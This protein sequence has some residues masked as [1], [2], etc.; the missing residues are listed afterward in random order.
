M[1]SSYRA[2]LA[3]VC[4]LYKLQ[5]DAMTLLQSLPKMEQ[6]HENSSTALEVEAFHLKPNIEKEA[7]KQPLL[8]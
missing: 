3:A 6:G 1:M 5:N 4:T 2:S 7:E 8:G